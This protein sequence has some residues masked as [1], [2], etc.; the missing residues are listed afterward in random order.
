M[1]R[2]YGPPGSSKDDLSHHD[3]QDATVASLAGGE[4]RKVWS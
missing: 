3:A 1:Q 2:L 4:K